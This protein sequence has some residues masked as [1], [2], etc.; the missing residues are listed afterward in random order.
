LLPPIPQKLWKIDD[1]TVGDHFFL[2]STDQCFY[3]WEYAARKGYDFSPANKFVWNLK[4]K[5]SAIERSP[6]RQ[7]HKLEAIN[8]AGEA[9][10]GFISREFVEASATF[11]PIPCSKV[12]RD[13]EYDNRLARVLSTAFLGWKA[14]IRDMLK[15]TRSTP[16]DHES[17]E[18][19]GFD[20]LLCITEAAASTEALL[21]PIVVLVDDVL[22][23]GKHF[24]VAQQRIRERY[25][26]AEI[27]GLFLARCVRD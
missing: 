23:S 13:P 18:R 16:A 26:G 24:K 11:I 21:R 2:D 3:I 6:L 8:H 15:I 9:L 12:T 19:L 27:R 7:R 1:S 25:V 4:I 22:N 20:E 17:A 10:R 14:D 5:P